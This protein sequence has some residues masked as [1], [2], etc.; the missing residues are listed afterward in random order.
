MN[1]KNKNEFVSGSHDKSI[2]VWDAAKLKCIQTLLGH[3]QGI[4]CVN[5]HNLGQQIVSAS[6]E[7]IAKLWDLKTGKATADLKAHTKRVR[8]HYE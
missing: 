8:I 2:K 6:P 3:T 7:G 1:P 5:Y 4:W